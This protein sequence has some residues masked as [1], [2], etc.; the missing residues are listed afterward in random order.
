MFYS[1]CLAMIRV[2]INGFGRIGRY[3]LRLASSSSDI[4][5]TAI[6]SSGAIESAAHLT[7]YDSVHGAFKENIEVLSEDTLKV[8]KQSIHYSRSPHPQEIPWK[9][10]DIVLDC[11]G[12]FKKKKDLSQHLKNE[13]KK[14]IIA[15]PAEEVDWTVVYGVNHQDYKKSYN[16][17][18][19]ASCTTNCLA[20]LVWGIHQIVGIESGYMTT[21]HAY[22]GDQ[23]LLDS[24]HKDLRRARAAG[25]SIIPTTTGATQAIGKILP[26]LKGALKGLAIRV[27]V[28]NVSLVE[29]AVQCQKDVTADSLHQQL[30]KFSKK[31]LKGVLGIEHK[32]LV[33]SDFI[34]NSLSAIV[35][36]PL[37]Q[38]NKNSLQIWAWYDNEAGYSHRLLDV[39]RFITAK[40][41]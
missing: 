6:N 15:A 13:V 32:P 16:I 22:T 23:K 33:S 40:G 12:K 7:Q 21:V 1:M 11:T 18:S 36:A 20:P 17:I 35:D 5:V 28:S 37:T 19:N 3:F 25:V 27:P 8:G 38:T 30:E 31:E 26:E 34:G 4:S 9:D 29:L 14:V 24:S 39:M 2:G 41:L 10:V